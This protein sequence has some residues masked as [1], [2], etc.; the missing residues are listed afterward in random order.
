MLMIQLCMTTSKQTVHVPKCKWKKDLSGRSF[1]PSMQKTNRRLRGRTDSRLC[2]PVQRRGCHGNRVLFGDCWEINLGHVD[3][4][5]AGSETKSTSK[6]SIEFYRSRTNEP[7]VPKKTHTGKPNGS[8]NNTN[9]LSPMKWAYC[10]EALASC[11]T[12]VSTCVFAGVLKWCPVAR[13]PPRPV[14][15]WTDGLWQ[16][17]AAVSLN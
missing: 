4:N 2:N 16:G 13:G 15:S 1:C 14:P 3:S 12:R 17:G 11:C 9:K 6:R 7:K 5:A 8:E 10:C